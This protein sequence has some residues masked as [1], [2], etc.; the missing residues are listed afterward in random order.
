ML[1]N[2]YVF[3]KQYIYTNYI[4]FQF[5][6]VFINC[7]SFLQQS[8]VCQINILEILF[9]F[10]ILKD[11]CNQTLTNKGI[12]LTE[13]NLELLWSVAVSLLLVG[14]IIGSSFT[15]FLADRLGRYSI[16]MILVQQKTLL[17]HLQIYDTIC[18]L[19]SYFYTDL[20]IIENNT[21]IYFFEN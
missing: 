6:F 18:P 16:F 20:S 11:F 3:T 17:G 12:R 21:I 7:L 15:G 4:Y 9:S 14:A 8:N 13:N 19:V 10:Q 5:L 2:S 1:C